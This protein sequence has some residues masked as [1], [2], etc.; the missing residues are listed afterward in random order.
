MEFWPD[1]RVMIEVGL[2]LTFKYDL[3]D[4]CVSAPQTGLLHSAVEGLHSIR[5]F[6]TS[7]PIGDFG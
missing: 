7:F 1:G 2:L 6:W 4:F 5:Y 3:S